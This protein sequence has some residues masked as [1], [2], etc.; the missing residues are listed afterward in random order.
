MN[1]A[2]ERG[3]AGRRLF[4][5]LWPGEGVRAR[6]DAWSREL[7]ALCGGR[8]PLAQ[9]LHLTLAFLGQVPAGRIG[10]V[11]RAAE[12]TSP[13]AA[14]LVLDRPGF[15]KHNRIAWA[16]ASSVPAELDS[17]VRRLREALTRFRIAFDPKP[18]V[19]HVTL[20]RDAREPRALPALE[21]VR[22]DLDGFV[23]AG[24][25]ARGGGRYEV[26]RSWGT[27]G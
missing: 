16:G 21:P 12:E 20:L 5:A 3:E 7:Q 26:I 23:L 17:L 11:E 15:W 18:F 14:T 25:S 8:A 24:P 27:R 19:P 22:W 9:D 2:A 4:F 1:P 13:Q 6:L 10:E